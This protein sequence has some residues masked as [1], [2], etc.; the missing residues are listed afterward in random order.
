LVLVAS[1]DVKA[2]GYVTMSQ[3]KQF[4][5]GLVVGKFCPLHKGHEF[6]INHALSACD[7]VTIISYS[8]PEFE[9][10]GRNAREAWLKALFPQAE[11]LVIDDESLLEL[12]KRRSLSFQEIPH[13]DAG[14][15]IH[16]Q[17]VGWLCVSVLSHTVDAVFTSEDYGDGFAKALAAY[18][19]RHTP[20][21]IHVKHVCVDKSRLAVPISGTT[22]RENPHLHRH[23]LSP[24]VYASF[25]KRVCFL[26]GE[27][28]GKTTLAQLLAGRIAT[29]WVPEYGRELWDRKQGRLEY[30]DLLEIALT[31][32][33]RENDY[34]SHAN[35]W[36]VCDTSPLTTLFYSLT[37]FGKAAP[38]LQALSYRSYDRIFLCAP[39][40]PFVQDGT[41]QSKS[42]RAR[43][44]AWYLNELSQRKIDFE[45]VT[46]SLETRT[47]TVL[48]SLREI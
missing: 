34:S 44:H 23:F 31:Q 36:L 48:S 2:C 26:G 47:V 17:F 4:K 45:V 12:C 16:R 35:K 6:H 32:V 19:T 33:R 10:C 14:D 5:R 7:Q 20:T 39:D 11:S 42:F 40:F 21:P 18:F 9:H 27:S 28:S 29:V 30:E 37:M 25:V 41:R 46:G 8:K 24:I 1:L 15:D 13:N 38:E 3:A 43:Q 22:I